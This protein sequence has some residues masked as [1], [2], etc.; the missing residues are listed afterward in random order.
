MRHGSGT[1]KWMS[2]NSVLAYY[3][4]NWAN[5]SMDGSGKYYY[6]SNDYPYISGTFVKGKLEG[7]AQYYKNAQQTF[8]TTWASGKCKNNNG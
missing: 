3:S 6:S 7:S 1:Y 4:G 5:D 2:G 8:T